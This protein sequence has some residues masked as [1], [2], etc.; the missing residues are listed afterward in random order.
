MKGM[1]LP[2]DL[3]LPLIK[4]ELYKLGKGKWKVKLENAATDD[5]TVYSGDTPVYVMT[6]GDYTFSQVS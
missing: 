6:D 3:L 5:P 1:T 2:A 4:N